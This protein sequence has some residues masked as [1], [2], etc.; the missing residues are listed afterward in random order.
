VGFASDTVSDQLARSLRWPSTSDHDLR[1]KC[2]LASVSRQLF[3]AFS[4]VQVASKRFVIKRRLGA[5]AM[6]VVYEVEAYGRTGSLALKLLRRA[7]SEEAFRLKREFRILST[8]AHP[9]LV[10][11]HELFAD[12]SGA[13]FTMEH[14]QGSDFLSYVCPGGNLVPERLRTVVLQLLD[15][16][17]WLHRQG[18]VHRDLKPSNV[19]IDRQGRA[20]LLDFGL[21]LAGPEHDVSGTRRFMAPEQGRGRSV[22]ASDLYA[23][24]VMLEVALSR[25]S[26][27]ASRAALDPLRVMERLCSQMQCVDPHDRPTAADALQ[28]LG[29]RPQRRVTPRESRFVGRSAELAQLC[30][31]AR[32]A[33]SSPQLVYIEALSGY[34]KSALIGEFVR[35]LSL[36]SA[37]ILVLRGRCCRREALQHRALDPLF[38]ALSDELLRA[39]AELV[40]AL[41]AHVSSHLLELVPVLSRVPA[42]ARHRQRGL[43]LADARERRGAAVA[44][45][46]R[47]LA[48]LVKTRDL[49]LCIDDVHWLDQESLQLMRE[50]MG[51]P[52][53]P[54]AL[55]VCAG[56]PH[57]AG[58]GTLADALALPQLTALSLGPL[59][60]GDALLLASALLPDRCDLSARVA[61][62]SAGNPLLLTQLSELALEC[63]TLEERPGLEG[64]VALRVAS[65]PAFARQV[66][67][68]V[69]VWGEPVQ[70]ELLSLAISASR[71]E[72]DS[73]LLLLEAQHYLRPTTAHPPSVE[74][75]HDQIAELVQHSLSAPARRDVHRAIAAALEQAGDLTRSRALWFHY[76]EAGDGARALCFAKLAAESAAQQLSFHEAAALFGE[77]AELAADAEAR[78]SYLER[79][80]AALIDAGRDHE[81]AGIL[82]ALSHNAQSPERRF[83]LSCKAADLFFAAGYAPEAMS[84][85]APFLNQLGLPSHSSRLGVAASFVYYRMRTGNAARTL[86]RAL[87][88]PPPDGERGRADRQ[89]VELCLLVARGSARGQFL[90]ALDFASRLPF[91]LRRGAA[92]DQL[93]R[94]LTLEA[95]LQ[96]IFAPASGRAEAL[97]ARAEELCA[98]ERDPVLHGRVLMSLAQCALFRLDRPTMQVNAEQAIQL[99]EGHGRG[100][101]MELATARW[102]WHLA[103]FGRGADIASE[104]VN[105]IMDAVQRGDRHTEKSARICLAVASLANGDAVRAR[106]ETEAADALSGHRQ[107]EALHWTSAATHARIDL[108]EGAPARAYAQLRRAVAAMRRTGYMLTPWMRTELQY[109]LAVA[110]LG[111]SGASARRCAQTVT[112][113]LARDSLPWAQLLARQLRAGLLARA[114]QRERASAALIELAVDLTRA[115]GSWYAWGSLLLAHQLRGLPGEAPVLSTVRERGSPEPARFLAA[116]AP[117]LMADRA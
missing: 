44:G 97:L 28:E 46:R 67:Q 45:L 1:A 68:I 66:L 12:H 110:A 96:A 35:G 58:A 112:D 10:V 37:S 22:A 111:C 99:F 18:I 39:S 72:L 17:A 51:G 89:R 65:L 21:A 48:L 90:N 77:C 62:T 34:G 26:P 80:A 82:Q 11:L 73:A 116:Y 94:A 100:V 95:E 2:V 53:A 16:L 84:L 14:I 30:A 63:Q 20:V 115:G 104:M 101:H 41:S 107:G 109:L 87:P 7:G 98:R 23:L 47:L 103:R 36:E 92:P 76:R 27:D 70:V 79:R 61:V 49:V 85:L 43:A 64:V 91:H 42:F 33:R 83:E 9:N 29:G 5:G 52:D 32:E 106:S 57:G 60:S 56:R 105:L 71:A 3:G 19:L 8:L 50:L 113:K 25:C 38:D 108:F 93:V 117:L 54:R 69:T 88:A 4:E 74:P 55:W 114:G 86:L 15:G 40:E 75:N 31:L 81:A 24:G 6:G 102:M 59:S 13:A 78:A